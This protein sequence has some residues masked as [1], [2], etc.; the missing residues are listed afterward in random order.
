MCITLNV[1]NF[2]DSVRRNKMKKLLVLALVLSMATLASASLSIVGIPA[3][4]ITVG[5]T[6]TMSIVSSAP[7]AFGDGTDWA[8]WG[9]VTETA[10]AGIA[11][12]VSTVPT[13]PGFVIYDGVLAGA[14]FTPPVGTEGVSGALSVTGAAVPA[15][16]I[17]DSITF[18]AQNAGTAHLT[19]VGTMD[20]DVLTT[21]ATGS[22]V[23]TPEPV[24]MALLGLGGLFLRRRSK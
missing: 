11:G 16:T 13:E 18:T 9:L 8:G 17:F 24:T 2:I 3:G 20:Y 6:F 10:L 19:L 15:G 4:P 22:I 23:I 12:G 7:I 14:G 5:D 21:L 1:K